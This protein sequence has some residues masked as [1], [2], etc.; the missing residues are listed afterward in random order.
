M[1]GTITSIIGSAP[2]ANYQFIILISP[3]NYSESTNTIV[4][5]DYVSLIGDS[6]NNPIIIQNSGNTIPI[7]FTLIIMM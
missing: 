3:G 1:D 5:P 4:V 2:S 7:Q 6:Y